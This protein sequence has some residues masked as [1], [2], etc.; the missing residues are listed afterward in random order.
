MMRAMQATAVRAQPITFVV[1]MCE[2]AQIENCAS[3][4]L[5]GPW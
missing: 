4:S 1:T 2:L 3:L 5:G